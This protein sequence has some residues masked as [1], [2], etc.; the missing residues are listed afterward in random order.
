MAETYFDPEVWEQMSP[1]E[2]DWVRQQLPFG[3]ESLLPAAGTKTWEPFAQPYPGLT[4]PRYTGYGAQYPFTGLD[5]YQPFPTGYPTL[6]LPRYEAYG[7]AYPELG[8]LYPEAGEAIGRLLRG[9]GLA[10]PVEELMEAYTAEEQ[11]ALEKYMPELR[12][13]FAERRLLRSGMARGAE[14]EAITRA[15]TARG[16]YRAELEKESAVRQQEGMIQGLGLA[17]QFT[18]MGYEAQVGAWSAANQEY[19][20]EYASALQA[21]LSESEARE[22]GWTAAN[23]EY[24]RQFTS[25]IEATRF[26]QEIQERAYT[27]AQSEYR[28]VYDSAIAAGISEYQAQ[29]QAWQ[30]A[31][32]EYAR[33]QQMGYGE[34][35][36]KLEAELREKLAEMGYDA[37]QTSSIWGAIGTIVGGIF[38]AIL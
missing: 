10:L 1:E 5:I 9:E 35:M 4:L 29:A 7:R 15:A 25:G 22:R 18:G 17:M 6:E 30:A 19:Q 36:W 14:E 20:R 28:K 27:S 23:Q 3:F 38:G 21:G 34:Y 33:I 31:Q 11:R 24:I 2:Q 26:S 8:E 37:Q 32:A 16:T 12:E 13:T